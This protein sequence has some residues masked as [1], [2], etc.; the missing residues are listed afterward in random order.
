[1]KHE[2]IIRLSKYVSLEVIAHE[3]NM[4]PATLRTRMH[5][6]QDSPEVDTAVARIITRLLADHHRLLLQTS[7][8]TQAD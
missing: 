1:M 7:D 3:A 8:L 6:K 2:D 4:N 5:R